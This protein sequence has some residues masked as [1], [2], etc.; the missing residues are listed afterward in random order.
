[1]KTQKE[2]TM[3]EVGGRVEVREVFEPLHQLRPEVGA[4]PCAGHGDDLIVEGQ[5]VVDILRRGDEEDVHQLLL[6]RLG[7]EDPALGDLDDLGP[8]REVVCKRRPQRSVRRLEDKPV[9]VQQLQR[10]LDDLCLLGDHVLDVRLAEVLENAHQD[11]DQAAARGL[12]GQLPTDAV[13]DVRRLFAQQCV[14]AT[15][16]EV[17]KDAGG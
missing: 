12:L 7:H 14:S 6:Q 17:R 4:G 8:D 3:S 16:L 13:Q 11:T 1:M 5:G 10:L 9:L 15:R 2:G